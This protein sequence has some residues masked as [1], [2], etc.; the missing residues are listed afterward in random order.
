MFK[1]ND[2]V[3]RNIFSQSK[4]STGR[5]GVCL[6]TDR[7]VTRSPGT[8]NSNQRLRSMRLGADSPRPPPLDGAD[9][10]AGGAEYCG[11]E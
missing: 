4:N 2:E 11:A 1:Q 3:G 7:V 8:L 10:T 9:R 6:T 5:N